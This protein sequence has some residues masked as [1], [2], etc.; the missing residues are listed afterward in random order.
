MDQPFDGFE[1]LVREMRIQAARIR[2]RREAPGVD[3]WL[4][5]KCVHKGGAV[6]ARI[7]RCQAQSATK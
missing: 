4:V 2:V 3:E 5:L 7:F 1:E 6:Y